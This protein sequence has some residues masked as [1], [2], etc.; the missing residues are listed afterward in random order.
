MI[1]QLDN[2]IVYRV[3]NCYG[4]LKS[5][6]VTGFIKDVDRHYIY[7]QFSGV[8]IQGLMLQ[9]ES[10]VCESD[11]SGIATARNALI[12]GNKVEIENSLR[13]R[14]WSK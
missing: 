6:D 12:S 5:G 13:I 7:P 2:E 3:S 9:L 8:G 10:L 14:E 1:K 11:R 4:R